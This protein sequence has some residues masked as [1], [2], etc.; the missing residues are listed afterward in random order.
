[1]R[2]RAQQQ[3]V[4]AVLNSETSVDMRQWR[5]W[6][7]HTR[8]HFVA[9]YFAHV[10]EDGCRPTDAPLLVA[11][12]QKFALR[13]KYSTSWGIINAW[14][15][16]LPRKQAPA[17]P[18]EAMWALTVLGALSNRGAFVAVALTCFVGVFPH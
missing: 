14:R 15:D 11:A 16:T 9:D 3:Y 10:F 1:M 13:G 2:P 7:V 17:C 6:R 12:L 5:R 18:V 8:D 4:E